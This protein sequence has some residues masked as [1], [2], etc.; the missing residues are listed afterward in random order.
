MSTPIGK[1]SWVAGELSPSMQG[2]PDE[3]RYANGATTLRNFFV[4]YR[5]PAYSRAGTAFVGFSKQT[6]RAYPPRMVPFQFNVNQG[7]A[8]EFG[9]FYMRVVSDGAFVVEPG[10]FVAGISQANPGVLTLAAESVT[11]ATANVGAVSASYNT[12]DSVTIAGGAFS[13]PAVL[14]VESTQL[15]SLA[16]NSRGNI[17]LGTTR[18]YLPGDTITLAGGTFSISASL[19]VNTTRVLQ[20]VFDP[21]FAGSG[22]APGPVVLTGTTGTGTK[23]QVN[24]TIGG[25]GSLTAVGSLVNPGSYTANPTFTGSPFFAYVEPVTGG[26]LSGAQIVLAMGID[27]VSILNPGDF[28]QNALGGNFTQNSSSGQGLGATFNNALFGPRDLTVVNGGIYG[29]LPANPAAQAST[30]GTGLGATFNLTGTASTSFSTGDWVFLSGIGGMTE[31]NGDTVVLTALSST[32]FS[33]QDVYG[34]NIDTTGFPAFTA[35]GTAARVFTLTTPFA[36]V[37]LPYLK[38]VQS[39]DEMSLCCVNQMTRVEYQPI[40]L[41][42]ITDIDWTF[43]P[44]VASATVQPP[45]AVSGVSSG[46][47]NIDYQYEVTSVDPANGT[48]SIASPIAS[49]NGAINISGTAGTIQLTWTPVAG[50]NQYNVYKVTPGFNTVPPV[51]SLFGF[52]GS[53]FGAQ[54]IDSNIVADETQVPP[55]NQNPFARGQILG[56]TTNTQGTGYAQ[57]TTTFTINTSTGSG[58]VVVPIVVSGGVVAWLVEEAGQNYAPTDTITIT[59]AGTGA[60][61]TLN[62]GAQTGTYPSV[63]GYFQERRAYA[64]TLNSPDTYFMSQPGAFTNFDSR[65]PTIASDAIIGSPWAVQVN[66]IQAMI[67]TSGGLLVMTGLSAWLLAGAGSFATNV[68]PISPSSQDDVPQ[69]FTGCS[70]IVPPIKINYD[71]IYVNS[72][73]SYYYDLPYQLY[74]LSE[75]I[76]LTD[77]SSHLFINYTIREH[78]WCEQPYK[79]L[80]AVRDDGVML[81]M[82]YYKTQQI[83]GWARHDTDGL[84]VSVCSV[85]ELPV[86]ALYLAT[87][88][89]PGGRTAYMIERMD[90]RIWADVEQTWCVDCGLT[91]P[92]PEPVATLTAN[93]AFGLGAISGFTGLVG[94][95]GYSAATTVTVVDLA[96]QADGKTPIGSGATVTP[97]IVGGVIVNLVIGAGGLNYQQPIFV[98]N[99]PAGSAGGQGF[100]AKPTLNNAT[101][102]ETDAAIFSAGDV[103]KVIRMGGGIAVI[104]VFANAIAV[105]ANML[106]PITQVV[107]GTSTPLPQSAGDWT[108]TAPVTLISG[109]NHLIDATVTGLADGNVIPPQVVSAQGT[110]TLATP[111]S[112]V[113]VGLGFTCQM[114]TPPIDTGTPTVQGQRKKLSAVSVRLEASRGVTVGANQL[115]GSVQSPPQIAPN[116]VQMDNLPDE[117][118]GAPNFPRRPYNA[119]AIPLRT[120]DVRQAVSGGWSTPGQVAIQQMHPLPCQV[121][122]VVGEYLGGDT[123]QT[124][125]PQKGKK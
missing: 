2:R 88:R 9:N 87:Q 13:S 86:D 46:A 43:T 6:G 90:N 5:G 36:E 33:M 111:A 95:Q 20:A 14:D 75:P 102:F 52:A 120:G 104:T 1:W 73:G 50:V 96:V 116:W 40:D 62:V 113:T 49:I 56:I 78:A 25:G 29:T 93:S 10:V 19:V 24:A 110:I 30:T 8:L 106:S 119:L 59:G 82:T 53:S 85:I 21:S 28:T 55:T 115:D 98:V 47:G 76:D 109:L 44:I 103:G 97:T 71:V 41:S 18:S 16:I 117:G 58:L 74:A 42:R 114:Q 37:D 27:T 61:A 57:G 112:A 17:V 39:A 69:A 122:A 125:A 67:Q 92:Q 100:A 51:G 48:E 80:W 65:I 15:A 83:A 101:L 124:Q 68:Q 32:T 64:N 54:F 22:G 79:L 81:S 38:F 12:G 34:N 123:P 121:L 45:S 63:P 107:P 26:G 70:P 108:M 89:F 94:G 4:S 72:K 84:F 66:G 35:G 31:L 91:L 23:F 3:A 118:S 105:Q 77:I 99:D 7:L 60:T 11:N